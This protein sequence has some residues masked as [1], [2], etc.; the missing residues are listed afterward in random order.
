MIGYSLVNASL[1]LKAKVD[2]LGRESQLVCGRAKVLLWQL[3]EGIGVDGKRQWVA[4]VHVVD[5]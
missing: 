5:P 1:E 2:Y 4:E 3:I